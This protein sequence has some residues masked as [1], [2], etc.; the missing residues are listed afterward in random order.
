MQL[1]GILGS[2]DGR[3]KKLCS[4]S[5][6]HLVRVLQCEAREGREASEAGDRTQS[7]EGKLQ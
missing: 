6:D 1:W 3:L 2:A 7:G 5:R 4:R